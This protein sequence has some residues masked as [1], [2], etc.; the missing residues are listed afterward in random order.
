MD[1]YKLRW[2]LLNLGTQ[3]TMLMSLF[4]CLG[5]WNSCLQRISE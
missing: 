5:I 4:V 2:N 1:W 3:E